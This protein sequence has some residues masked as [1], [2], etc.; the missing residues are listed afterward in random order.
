M[1]NRD[2]LTY[3][4]AGGEQTDRT[5][6]CSGPQD[7]SPQVAAADDCGR[8]ISLAAYRAQMLERAMNEIRERLHRLRQLRVRAEL[9][10]GQLQREL[11]EL[12][13]QLRACRRHVDAS[14]SPPAAGDVS[15][16]QM[17]GR[18]RPT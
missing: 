10:A 5:G 8:V 11:M 15:A 2:D 9:S 3:Q 12:E 7:P 4:G 1:G 17:R 16:G 18:K 6:R 13:R 14:C